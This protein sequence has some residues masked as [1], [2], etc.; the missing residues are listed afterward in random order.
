MKKYI[1]SKI[2]RFKYKI[3]YKTLYS[4]LIS[5]LGIASILITKNIINYALNKDFVNLKI[6]TLIF[7][8]ITGIT[9]ILS[10]IN[11]YISTI[12]K[13][14]IFDEMQ[15]NLYK[16]VVN[17]KFENISKYSSFDIMNRI[18]SDC[19][20]V[21]SFIYDII[22]AIISLIITIPVSVIILIN[23]NYIFLLILLI[24]TTLTSIFSKI[25]NNKQRELYKDIQN[26]DIEHRTTIDESL[27]NIEYIKVSELEEKNLELLKKIHK[28]RMYI[29]KKMSII[30]GGISSFFSLGSII[31]YTIIFVIGVNNLF[32]GKLGIAEFTVLLQIYRQI[33]SSILRFQSY[34][35]AFNNSLAAADRIYEIELL[36]IENKKINSFNEFKDEIQ[37]NNISFEYNDN[38]IL[39][40]LSFN[41]KKGEI[42][43]IIGES[44]SGKTTLLKLLSSLLSPK[45]GEILIDGHK[46]TNDHRNLISYVPQ[47]DML[48]SK[49]IKENLLYN[50]IYLDN[51]ELENILYLTKIDSFLYKLPN[52]I[53]TNIKYLSKGQRQRVAL[54][55]AIIQKKPILL[56]DEVTASLDI[57]TEHHIIN[58]IKSLEHRPT[59]IIVTHRKSILNICNKVFDI[60]NKVLIS[61]TL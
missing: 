27:K 9:F 46:L 10:P 57:D 28:N 30:V 5:L 8:F 17:S 12:L 59:C 31:S 61:N 36:E 33:D 51:N 50:D 22:P 48:F 20:I 25:L 29:N 32:I 52:G 16:K 18:N 23:I 60:K 24:A 2:I 19:E 15:Y 43:G 56:L 1:F 55:R 41:I 14:K 54:A 13:L 35:P 7:I 37:I 42:Y 26:N 4:I 38:K 44:G 58:S 39:K 53:N 6:T 3:L 34:I 47:D 21:I 11:S 40:D 49:S 45:S